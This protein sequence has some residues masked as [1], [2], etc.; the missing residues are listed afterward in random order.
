ME[1]KQLSNQVNYGCHSK[2]FQNKGANSLDA[3]VKNVDRNIDNEIDKD[4]SKEY[5]T[6]NDIK[7]TEEE[8]IDA[9]ESAN[10]ELVIYDRRFEFSIHDKTKHI[11][12]KVLDSSTDEVIREIPPEKILDLVGSLWE[13]AGIIIDE[14]I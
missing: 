12:V 13:I 3:E 8:L 6:T 5:I 10:D 2:S 7:Y 14:K 11:M 9:I 1:V 4:H